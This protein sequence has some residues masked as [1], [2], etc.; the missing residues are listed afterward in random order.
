MSWGLSQPGA[1]AGSQPQTELLLCTFAEVSATPNSNCE[2][3]TLST[4]VDLMRPEVAVDVRDDFRVPHSYRV[5]I[6]SPHLTVLA[7]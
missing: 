6:V 5:A 2:L 4:R 3:F 7:K 1:E